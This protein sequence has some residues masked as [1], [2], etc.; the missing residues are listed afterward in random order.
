[1][2]AGRG[3]RFVR[4]AIPLAAALLLG[5]GLT[6]CEESE[7][8]AAPGEPESE[9]R[10]VRI[11]VLSEA[12]ANGTYLVG[13]ELRFGAWVGG[14]ETVDWTGAIWL[15][16]DL[17]L[18]RQPAALVAA[19]GGRLEFAYAVRRGDYDGD[20]VSAAEGELEFGSGATLTI[21]GQTVDA[22]V[23]A[24]APAPDHRVYGVHEPGEAVA[25]AAATEPLPGWLA[26]E[27]AVGCRNRE[28]VEEI[29]RAVLAGDLAR[30]AAGYAAGFQSGRCASLV[31]GG[32]GIFL[33]AAVFGEGSDIVDL[34]LA[35]GPGDTVLGGE[36]ANWW[37]LGAFVETP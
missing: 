10:I 24:L 6:G 9:G 3:R 1:M 17:G 11:E 32:Q 31:P 35:Y 15:V 30:A 12:G 21:S 27:E 28:E 16:F 18:A 5:L 13:E 20:G 2:N 29:V 36:T 25:F 23:P 4:T 22:A 8:P 14:G 26:S 34:V 7:T 37:T 19:D 33:S